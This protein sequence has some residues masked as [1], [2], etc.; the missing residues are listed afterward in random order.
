MAMLGAGGAM[1][2]VF[3]ATMR[4]VTE[5]Q[6]RGHVA[7]GHEPHVTALAP[8]TAVGSAEGHMGFA[9]HRDAA[10]AAVSAP[11]VQARLVDKSRHGWARLSGCS[12]R[13]PMNRWELLDFPN[14]LISKKPPC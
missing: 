10:G 2:S 7:V 4:M 9:Q 12:T 3:G 5:S 13:L 8:V 14:P 1:G 6:Q 11:H